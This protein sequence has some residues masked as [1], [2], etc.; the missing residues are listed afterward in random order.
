MTEIPSILAEHYPFW[1]HLKADERHAF[2]SCSMIRGYEKGSFVR[3]DCDECL[4]V[5]LV[6]SGELRI[7]I[8]SD[9]GREVTL[10]RVGPGELCTL[11]ASCVM[12][13]ITFDIYVESAEPSQVLITRAG[14]VHRFMETNIYVENFIYKQTA[15]RFSDVMWAISQ[16]L[17]SSFDKRLAS[18]LEDERRRSGS[19]AITATHDQIAKNLG[20]AR[21][22]VSRMLKYFEKEGLVSLSRGTVTITDIPRLK[23]LTA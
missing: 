21:E 11:S 14:C 5:L 17:F 9:E 6:L 20:S 13:E 8:Q 1:E 12:S 22:V 7:Y 16:I 2:V 4:G 19:T 10:F 3:S 15:E 23:A 18:Y